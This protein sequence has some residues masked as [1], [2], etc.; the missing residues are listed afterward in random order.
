MSGAATP[1]AGPSPETLALG[2]RALAALRG[3]DALYRCESG[4]P[5]G[6]AVLDLGPSRHS[7]PDE[8]DG[9]GAARRRFAE[10]RAG[11]A[12]LPEPDRRRYYEDL[13]ASTLAFI[14]WRDEGLAFERQLSE[15]LHVPAAPVSEGE[16]DALRRE[17]RSLLDEA[18]HTGDLTAAC[19]D[20]EDRTRVP[21]DEVEGTLQE[22]MD[23]ALDRTRERLFE[24]PASRSD[25]M[26]VRGVRGAAFNARCDYAR[27]TVEVN[28]DPVL[29]LPGL[30]HLA[31]HE[32]APG[33]YA[34][35]TLRRTMAETGEAAPDV[36]LSVVNTASSCVFE[37]IADAGMEMLGWT[38]AVDDRIEACLGRL[39]AGIGTGAA[40]RLHALGWPEERVR[41]WLAGQAL[42]GGEGWVENRMRFIAAPARAVLIWSY[43][44]GLPAVVR[45]WRRT[46]P[47]ERPAFLRFLHGRMHSLAS[48]RLFRDEAG[49]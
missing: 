47:A 46:A 30:R 37:G 18:G 1:D 14:A 44:H 9:Y 11:A 17:L 43:W 34:Q 5:D 27:R 24:I 25:R 26:R 45:E 39:R 42:V 20:W 32:G 6:L 48:V 4:D 8:F 13:C 19:A 29:T 33:H 10:L 36:L 38:E 12:E 2:G 23:R 7:P 22:L 15:F 41:G 40:W 35:F 49:G 16:L 3:L 28:V 21:A 31:V